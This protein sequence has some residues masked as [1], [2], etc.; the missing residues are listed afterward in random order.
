MLESLKCHAPMQYLKQGCNPV[1]CVP[2]AA[3]TIGRGGACLQSGLSLQGVS[4]PGRGVCPGG[5]AKG[6][7]WVS[8]SGKGVSAPVNRILET[9]L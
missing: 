4:A 6:G 2:S 7:V 8:A 9:R 3:V 1:G 5:S